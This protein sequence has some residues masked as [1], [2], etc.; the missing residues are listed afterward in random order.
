MNSMQPN[1]GGLNLNGMPPNMPPMPM[2]L[3]PG[4][5]IP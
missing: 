4:F 5:G 1:Q 2:G 3:P